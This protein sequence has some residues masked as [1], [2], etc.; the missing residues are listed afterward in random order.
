VA[1][2]ASGFQ[3]KLADDD[4]PL[5]QDDL[6]T[7]TCTRAIIAG[8]TYAMAN[9]TSVRTFVE[10]KPFSAFGGGLAVTIVGALS[11]A[12]DAR[13]FGLVAIAFGLAVVAAY[14]FVMKPKYWVRIGTA[15]AES[16]TVWSHDE[17]W[18]QEIVDAINDAIV[19]RG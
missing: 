17:A 5:F 6:V 18:C 8:T 3:R 1:K 13:T 4:E 9:V 14:L 16:N 10:P 12:A 7:V 11:F 19:A 2:R 15:G